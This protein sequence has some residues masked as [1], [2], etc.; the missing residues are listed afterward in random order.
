MRTS[1]EGSAGPP[2]GRAAMA[3]RLGRPERGGTITANRSP[4]RGAVASQAPAAGPS[5]RRCSA[6]RR[7]RAVKHETAKPDSPTGLKETARA[8]ALY[9]PPE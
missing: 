6:C 5:G 9:R 8:G 1:R 3:A 7:T 4:R 2:P